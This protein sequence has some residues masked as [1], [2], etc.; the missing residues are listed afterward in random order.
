ME[1]STDDLIYNQHDIPK[2]QWRYGLRASADTGCGWIATYNALRLLGYRT[3]PEQLIRYYEKQVPLING[4]AGT[5]V[6]GPA[7]RFRKWG[8]PVKTYLDREK[9]DQ[10]AKDADV[11]ILYYRWLKKVPGRRPLC[12]AASYRRRIYRLQYIPHLYRTRPLR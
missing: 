11:C 10:A 9:F 8:F 5:V 12:G 2:E 1:I 7:L 4:N 3:E 6:F